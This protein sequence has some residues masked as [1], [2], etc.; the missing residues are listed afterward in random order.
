LLYLE[1]ESCAPALAGRSRAS[2]FANPKHCRRLLKA[3]AWLAHS[4]KEDAVE[5]K[6]M[7]QLFQEV[8]N[9]WGS[10]DDF[11]AP[12]PGADPMPQEAYWQAT[13]TF[14]GDVTRRTCREYGTV[15]PAVDRG[16]IA[17]PA[18]AQ[19]IRAAS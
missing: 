10:F 5:R 2:L 3:Q 11:P 4:K 9:A 18:V 12:P 14:N 13:Q 7:L 15:H 6:R 8:Q 16:D 19:A 17:W 1:C